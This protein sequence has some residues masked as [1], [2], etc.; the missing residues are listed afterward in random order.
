M[1]D[2]QKGSNKPGGLGTALR[3]QKASHHSDLFSLPMASHLFFWAQQ[4]TRA[5]ALAFTIYIFMPTGGS[6]K[7]RPS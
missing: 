4:E 1:V 5:S 2:I 3:K 7:N 6:I